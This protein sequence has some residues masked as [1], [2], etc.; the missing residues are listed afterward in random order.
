MDAACVSALFT[1]SSLQLFCCL[2]FLGGDHAIYTDSIYSKEGQE[3]RKNKE[4]GER[5]KERKKE[6]MAIDMHHRQAR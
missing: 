3:E 1:R 6:T 2:S 5:K 4:T